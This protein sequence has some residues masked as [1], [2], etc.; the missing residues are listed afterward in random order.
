MTV[1]GLAE[2]KSFLVKASALYIIV[3]IPTLSFFGIGESILW[4]SIYLYVYYSDNLPVFRD[5][6]VTV[7]KVGWGGTR[8]RSIA[9]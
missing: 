8:Y 9:G 3:G 7:R 2:K 4:L 6:T 5:D 1:K